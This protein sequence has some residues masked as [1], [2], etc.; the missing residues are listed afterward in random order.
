MIIYI[1]DKV[2]SYPKHVISYCEL[3]MI[4]IAV[5]VIK[6]HFHHQ[7]DHEIMVCVVCLSVFLSGEVDD[8]IDK[9]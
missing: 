1:Y 9:K 8:I 4:I 7:L 2:S 6:I 3:I 5:M